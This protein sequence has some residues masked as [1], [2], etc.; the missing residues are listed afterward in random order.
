MTDYVEEKVKKF[1]TDWNLDNKLRGA[2]AAEFSV[3]DKIDLSQISKLRA[4]F[5]RKRAP[6]NSEIVP[7]PFPPRVFLELYRGVARPLFSLPLP[8]LRIA[9]TPC[10]SW[11]D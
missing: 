3:T 1:V 8:K 11:K 7:R 10:R 5:L 4:F 9:S 6:N 2:S